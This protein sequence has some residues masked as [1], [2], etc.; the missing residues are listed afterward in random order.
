MLPRRS[1]GPVFVAVPVLSAMVGAADV[2]QQASRPLA[3]IDVTVEHLKV[4]DHGTVY[5]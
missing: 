4:I 1:H 2:G 3:T 5:R